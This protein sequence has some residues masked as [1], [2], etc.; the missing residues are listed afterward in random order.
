MTVTAEPAKQAAT[1]QPRRTGFTLPGRERIPDFLANYLAFVA[2]FCAVTA[3]LPFLRSPLGWLRNIIELISVGAPPSLA[4][5]AF[6][7]I[8]A[9]AVRRRMRV[10]WWI[11]VVFL[12]LDRFLRFAI[13]V[14]TDAEQVVQVSVDGSSW[15]RALFGLLGLVLLLIARDQFTAHMDKGNGWRALAVYVGLSA[16]GIALGFLLLQA[17]PGTLAS[18]GERF[19]WSVTHVLVGLGSRPEL[20]GID[21][22]APRGVTFIC[23]VFGALAVLAAAYVLM[24]PRSFRRHL[25]PDDEQRLRVLLDRY[26][27]EDSLGYF[28]TRRDKSVI[29]SDSGKAAVTYR[30][31]SGVSLASGDPIGGQEAWPGAIQAWLDEARYHGWA[32]GVMAA[33]EA[34]AT[35]YIAAG[36]DAIELGD[37]AIIDVRDFS[38]EGRS[39]RVVRQ[40]V[41]RVERAGYTVRIR[42]HRELSAEE[43]QDVIRRADS[44]RDTESERGFSMALSRLGDAADGECV[45]VECMDADGQLRALLSFVPW[46]MNGLSLDLMRRDR[47]SENGVTEFMV[48]SLIE[49]ARTFGVERIS[50]NFAMF[51]S[52][53]EQGERIGRGP[54]LRLWRGFL[55]L[56]SKWWQLESLYRANAKYQPRWSPRFLCY[57]SARQLPRLGVAS[58]V[59]EGFIRTP[60][61]RALGSHADPAASVPASAPVHPAVPQPRVPGEQI[62]YRDPL[63]DKLAA[64]RAAL[65]EQAR[66]RHDTYD[67]LIAEG[68]DPYPVGHERTAT[69]GEVRERF[70]ALTPDASSGTTVAVTGRVLLS[71]SHGG[72]TFARLR[73]G[74]GDLQLMLTAEETGSE[75]IR[76]WNRNVDLGDHVGVVGEV[77]TSRRGELSVLVSSWAITAKC[78]RPLPDKRRGLSDPEAKVRQRYVDLIVNSDAR[79]M[80]RLRS[81]AVRAVRNYLGGRGFLEVET[82]ILQ[83]VHGGAN[84]RPFITHI[85]AYDM[86]LYLRIAPE[87]YLKRLMVGGAEKVFELNRT[88]RNEGAD[89]THNP[90]FTMLEAY[91][92]YGDYNTMQTLMQEMIQHAARAALG[93]T[94]VVHEGKEYDLG[95]QWRSMTVNDAI[96][97]ALGEEITADTPV[98]QLR[99]LCDATGIPY[100]LKWGRGLVL[101]EMYEHLAEDKTLEPTFYRD[102]PTDVSPLTRQHRVDPRLAERWDLV[103]FGAEIGTAYS[104]LVDPV[105]QRRRLTEQSLLA[106][107]GDP[108]AMELDEDFLA[109]LEYAMPPS[110]GLGMGVDRMVMMLTGKNI[111]ETVLF[112]LVRIGT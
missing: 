67:R 109:A 97:H 25:Q 6:L 71:R 78:L 24:R 22:S 59:A 19:G 90:E 74:T 2:T 40:A 57:A 5:A 72:V 43:M 44:W 18:Q 16:V 75:S 91:E 88:F 66:V 34:A 105:E 31:G 48:T 76:A 58:A 46:G 3:V 47:S 60:S 14:D 102:F 108:E 83:P 28:A 96:S 27:D 4:T 92:A 103:C 82:P 61:L 55:L 93:G 38:I 45:L 87:L 106:A 39:M 81:E 56:G 107:G 30:V 13:V 79:R 101:L 98:E 84:A 99:R 17:F 7:G 20:A 10:A 85:N 62:D 37:E 68:I 111:R 77:V 65:P 63:A 86:R 21:G 32:P 35:A 23:G 36:L 51:R 64:A 29:F 8:L 54:V 49:R 50:L 95:G 110:G 69:L 9:T 53:F 12:L 11:L 104:E 1:A 100:S 33:G 52:A 70:A 26:G 15:A 89:A 112:P 80:L 41:T 42:R 73:D 94:V